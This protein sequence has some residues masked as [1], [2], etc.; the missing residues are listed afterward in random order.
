MVVMSL[1]RGLHCLLQLRERLL[2][3]LRQIVGIQGVANAWKSLLMLL[4]WLD[5]LVDEPDD[6]LGVGRLRRR[7][8]LKRL[9]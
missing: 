2:A 3:G 6:V 1:P 4:G 8:R 5:E 9:L 7:L